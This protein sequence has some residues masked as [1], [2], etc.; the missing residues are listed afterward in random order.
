[1]GDV[2][3]GSISGVTSFGIFVVADEPFVEGLV[4]TDYLTPDDFYDFDEVACR[5]LGRRSGR[6][7]SLGDRVQ[8]Q[9]LQVSVARRRIELRL[10][11][12]KDKAQP[13]TRSRNKKPR[14][15]EALGQRP[16]RSQR[17][18]QLRKNNERRAKKRR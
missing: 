9:I 11:D 8:V 18:H 5:L 7:F 12:G 1:V 2:L 10:F 16:N 13:G 14:Q 4:R 6:T 3:E 15:K 17:R